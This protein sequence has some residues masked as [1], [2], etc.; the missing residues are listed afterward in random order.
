LSIELPALAPPAD[1]PPA[2]RACVVVLG[3]R[4]FAVDVTD[5]REV[6]MVD[7]T[8]PVPGAPATVIG[9]MNLRGHVMPVVD[10][11]PLLGLST[12]ASTNRALVVVDGERRAAILVESVLGLTTLGS[13]P[14]E[15]D[16]DDGRVMLGELNTDAGGRATLLDGRA[17]LAALRRA[18]D[19][20]SGG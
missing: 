4:R 3:D 12:R 19:P 17:M 14:P 1:G 13:A 5:A 11:R 7:K 20:A 15:A 2:S 6:V 16:E 9:V 10:A 18:W 8:T